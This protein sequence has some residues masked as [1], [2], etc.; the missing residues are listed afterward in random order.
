MRL[1]TRLRV[2][3]LTVFAPACDPTGPGGRPGQDRP[4]Q[5]PGP[6]RSSPRTRFPLTTVHL[7]SVNSYHIILSATAK[8]GSQQGNLRGMRNASTDRCRIG[9]RVSGF[10]S[11]VPRRGSLASRI[12]VKID[13]REELDSSFQR[14][15]C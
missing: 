14:G 1:R 3:V 10:K 7:K 15:R 4:Q 9:L 13:L 6:L 2:T 12:T 5:T 11:M 8:H